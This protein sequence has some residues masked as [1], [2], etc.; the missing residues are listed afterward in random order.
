MLEGQWTRQLNSPGSS[1]L[2]ILCCRTWRSLDRCCYGIHMERPEKP[3]YLQPCMH[4]IHSDRKGTC[5]LYVL[6]PPR[7][8]LSEQP[9]QCDSLFSVTVPHNSYP[10][11]LPQGHAGVF[12][13][14]PRHFL[15]QSRWQQAQSL[16]P[17]LMRAP[18]VPC[19]CVP[20]LNTFERKRSKWSFD[21]DSFSLLL[22]VKCFG[23][24]C[25][26]ASGFD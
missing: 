25:E 19:Q 21:S 14:S 1:A 15:I 8:C 23:W 13:T 26:H 16:T 24:R 20:T 11:K 9:I 17:T 12:F 2:S 3:V 10:W 6:F 7:F 18:F 5:I 22:C 4:S